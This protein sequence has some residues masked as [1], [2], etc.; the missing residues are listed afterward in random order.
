MTYYIELTCRSTDE[1]KFRFL[2]LSVIHETTTTVELAGQTDEPDL[3]TKLRTVRVPFRGL[4]SGDN[5]D[6][7]IL[8]SDGRDFLMMPTISGD[9]R[10]YAALDKSGL[11]SEQDTLLG[12]KF[13]ELS[14]AI[15]EGSE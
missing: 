2:G 14:A 8:I 13:Y 3:V 11:P 10:P 9:Q 12:R 5:A 7:A 1:P 4:S 6:P 15:K